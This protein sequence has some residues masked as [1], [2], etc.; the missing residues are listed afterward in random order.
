MEQEF[1]I[2]GQKPLAGTI[3]VRGA[4]NAALKI[5]PVALMTDEP[6][7][8]TNLPDIEDCHRAQ[9]MLI[10]LGHEVKN[11]G[12]GIM[13]I[14]RESKACV[15]L[16]AKLVNKF[17]ASIMFVGPLLATCGEV[18]FPHPGGCVIGAG[19]RP[20]DMFL[21]GFAKMGAKVEVSENSYR[22]TTQKLQGVNIF[23][24]KVT[25]TGTESLM[26]TACLAWGETV[27]EN[28][29][30]EP[31]IPA[32]AEFLNSIGA[33]I[34]GAGTP[35]IKIEGVAKLS[36]GEYKIMP[37][38]IEA[39]TFAILAAAANSGE[40]I[41]EDCQPKH[42]GA[43]WVLFDK[44]G[45]NYKLDKTSIKISPSDKIL[46]AD[47]VTHEYPGFAT[48]LQSAYTVL[49]TQAQGASLIH[50]TIY[51]RRLL[52]ADM[53]TQMGANIIMA[54]PHR[55]VV[56]GPTKLHSRKLMS[57]DLRAGMALI[58][59]ALIAEGT[60]EINNIYQIERGYEDLVGR[61]KNIGAD[62]EKV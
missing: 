23:F 37:D 46:A 12:N 7:K 40:I 4:K 14:R 45:V 33:K 20:I 13:E 43:L 27:L 29:A 41:I 5:F 38:R 8:I 39:G 31:E 11:L 60:T 32:L 2:N 52:F 48:D 56:S 9:E 19:T 61:L 50:E 28:C 21:D 58:I 34:T 22:L 16:P 15:N 6:I 30:M 25:V 3:K 10:A 51:D 18:Q 47:L 17:R 26:T 55:I 1:I 42:L 54:D 24:P 44:I 59:A 53:L 49:M 62:I 36:G 57:S 35:T